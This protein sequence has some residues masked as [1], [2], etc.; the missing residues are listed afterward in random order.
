M[1]NTAPPHTER[2]YHLTAVDYALAALT[3]PLTL[4]VLMFAT[5]GMA[6]L[7]ESPRKRRTLGLALLALELGAVATIV[8]VVLR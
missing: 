1:T 2:D 5:S 4:F 6:T 3:L 8:W 7:L